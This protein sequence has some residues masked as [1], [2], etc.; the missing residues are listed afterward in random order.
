MRPSFDV[1]NL[2][3]NRRPLVG[4]LRCRYGLA[5]IASFAC[6]LVSAG[7][8][9]GQAERVLAIKAARLIDGTGKPPIQD[10]VILVRGERIEAVGTSAQVRIPNGASVIDR[11][12]ET[13]LPGLIDA[14][15]HLSIRPDTRTLA[16]QLEGM[17]QPDGKQMLRAVRNIRIQLLSGVTTLY[18]V[19]EMHFND[20]YLAEAVRQGLVPGPRII[21]GGEFISTTAGHGPDESRNTD[22]PWELIKKVRR[23]AE[24]G[25]AHVKLTITD[26]MRV[27]PRAGTL[28]APGESNFTKH[29]MTV[30]VEE[31]HRL[32]LQVTAHANN[33][34][35]RLALESGVDSIQHG[36][37][38]TKELI[39]LLLEKR[40]G[41]VHTHTIGYQ[42][43]FD[44][45]AYLDNDAM[46]ADDWVSRIRSLHKQIDKREKTRAEQVRQR[47]FEIREAHGAGVPIAAGTDSM[48][49]LM[50]LE[51]ENLVLAG[52]SPM[53]AIA[54]ATGVAARVLGLAE[55]GSL[56]PG[57]MADLI[58]VKGDPSQEIGDLSRVSFV[59]VG[60]RRYDSLSFK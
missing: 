46:N 55:V 45:W 60:G 34:S 32:G 35:I 6:G 56:E 27:G 30:V 37:G 38:L 15:A 13:L 17:R 1:T 43:W 21:P 54:A 57:K 3:T 23:N 16:G 29:E 52:L 50:A 14:H 26:R 44:E 9:Y 33:D 18:V 48:H 42:T 41:I 31:A 28:L 7:P 40:K 51:I 22:G 5:L 10:A 53:D 36:Y 2:S 20:V 49:G 24:N 4:W 59:M 12:D 19:G 47:R 39:S 58:S 11:G 8:L 25:A